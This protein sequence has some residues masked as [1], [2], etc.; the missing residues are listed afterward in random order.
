MIENFNL[1]DSAYNLVLD[2]NSVSAMVQSESFDKFIVFIMINDEVQKLELENPNTDSPE[3]KKKIYHKFLMELIENSVVA[4]DYFWSVL[5]NPQDYREELQF[6]R[7][8]DLPEGYIDLD[9]IVDII[10]SMMRQEEFW[11]ELLD[12]VKMLQLPDGRVP[13]KAYDFA[14]KLRNDYIAEL[15]DG[16]KI[17]CIELSKLL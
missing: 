14:K 11:S 17:K 2:L 5:K 4:S 16:A 13:D 6:Y 10:S 3:F 7:T 9:A 12:T 15:T 1:E 8:Q